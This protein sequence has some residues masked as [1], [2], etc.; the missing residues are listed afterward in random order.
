M[1]KSISKPLNKRGLPLRISALRSCSASYSQCG[2]DSIVASLISR[3]IAPELYLDIGCYHPITWSNTYHFYRRGWKGLCVDASD[4]YEKEWRVFRP[5]DK[6]TIAAIIPSDK[7][8]V[9]KFVQDTGSD[10]TSFITT[11]MAERIHPIL[12][13]AH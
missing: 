11:T 6:H 1:F 8:K 5:Q 13:R 9:M 2:E 10:A 12:A 4:K 7:Y 3:D